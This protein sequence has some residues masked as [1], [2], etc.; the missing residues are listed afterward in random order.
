MKIEGNRAG[1]GSG[2]LAQ[3]V[4]REQGGQHV[5]DDQVVM[6]YIKMSGYLKGGGLELQR[7][8]SQSAFDLVGQ[9]KSTRD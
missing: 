3:G 7:A 4:P 8:N 5:L 2:I 9:F 1:L 6:P